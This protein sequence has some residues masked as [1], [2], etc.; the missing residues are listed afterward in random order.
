MKCFPSSITIK[1]DLS[2]SG[3][4]SAGT[5]TFTALM[6]LP[7]S[8]RWGHETDGVRRPKH[9]RN[10]TLV[11]LLLS[12]FVLCF[13]IQLSSTT[14]VAQQKYPVQ[15]KLE[16]LS[17]RGRS[18]GPIP[19]RIKLEY[20]SNQLL[21]GDLLMRIYNSVQSPDD[22]M[23]VIRYEGIVLQGADT[24]F[25]TVLPPFEHSFNKQYLIESWFET[26]AGSIPLSPDP[27]NPREPR[28]LLSIG[29]FERATL[30][31]SCSG[32]EDF[33]QMSPNRRFLNEALSL[34]EY[35]PLNATEKENALDRRSLDSQR[36]QN[37]AAGWDALDMPEDPL[38]LCCFD[39]VL[40]ADGALGR[41]DAAQLKAL[42]TWIQAGGSLCVLPDDRNLSGTHL[43]FLQTLFERPDDPGLG[44]SLTDQGQLLVISHRSQP[45]INRH[46]GL[47]RVTLLPDVQDLSS[48]LTSEDLGTIVGH[49]WKVHA[50]SPVFQGQP[51]PLHVPEQRI[52]QL[53]YKFQGNSQQGFRLTERNGM[54]PVPDVDQRFESINDLAVYYGLGADLQPGPS[55]L[56]AAC[57][58]A[59][60]P[61]DVEVV[62]AWIIGTLLVAYVLTIGPI[63]YLLLGFFR[64]RKFTWVL[65]PLVT[66]VFTGATIGIAHSYMAS[67]DT[68]GQLTITDL[69]DDGHPV[70]QTDF[71]LAF[72]GQKTSVTNDFTQQFVVLAQINSGQSQPYNTTMQSSRS[73]NTSMHYA[74]RFPNSFNATQ[75]LRQWE[76][77]T[78][79]LFTLEPD[80]DGIPEISWND[81]SAVTTEQG[82]EKLTQQLTEL[83]SSGQQMDAIIVHGTTQIPLFPENGFLFS[84]TILSQGRNWQNQS[85]QY[86]QRVHT[87]PSAMLAMGILDAS[88]RQ[89]TSDFF[90][91]VS[92]VSP[93]GSAPMEDLPICDPAD[94]NQWLLIVATQ[95]TDHIRIYRRLFI[96]QPSAQNTAH[97]TTQPNHT[98]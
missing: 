65:F 86:R 2:A 76:P 71:R 98:H 1:E 16:P 74:G 88:G 5:A 63:D 13:G 83:Q 19:L 66:A 70:R 15:L 53:G 22:L 34:D 37:Y 59:L 41:L 11:R 21:E 39:L 25:T 10:R 57:E 69:V 96:Q 12:T 49:L 85:I 31:C 58:T 46:C 35:N 61:Q 91:V 94:P 29:S 77:Q 52:L 95:Q 64:I 90:S 80:T 87:S 17:I 44:L 38:R 56:S 20:N 27:E 8:C 54:L 45:V 72:H 48:E 4:V 81:V 43:Q 28:E 36:I 89:T 68:G 6:R 78:T 47:G 32:D 60:M 62:P 92:Q 7:N 51:W 73:I 23:A 84:Q 50:G 79:R 97:N 30:I 93:Q 40:L 55:L 18:A 82:R 14:A 75:D 9:G 42:L 33:Q 26:E 3:I 67:S 24:I